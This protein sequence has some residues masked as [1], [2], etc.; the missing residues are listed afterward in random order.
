METLQP[1]LLARPVERR[2]SAFSFTSSEPGAQERPDW[3]GRSF[4][5][6]L[7][8]QTRQAGFVCRWLFVCAGMYVFS[9]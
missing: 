9:R 2:R 7:F 1:R 3:E 6:L 8:A 5:S 4:P